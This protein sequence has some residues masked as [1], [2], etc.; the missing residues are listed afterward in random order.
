MS[1]SEGVP[2]RFLGIVITSLGSS[3]SSRSSSSDRSSAQSPRHITQ[4]GSQGFTLSP[5]FLTHLL[6]AQ[7]DQFGVDPLGGRKR[8][9][10]LILW[11]PPAMPP[12]WP[13]EVVKTWG[14]ASG[15]RGEEGRSEKMDDDEVGQDEIGEMDVDE[16]MQMDVA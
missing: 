12:G 7:R 6:A 9:Q 10:G 3:S 13:S 1:H 2:L 4:P 14:A 8:E 11:R 5:S 15:S 16:D